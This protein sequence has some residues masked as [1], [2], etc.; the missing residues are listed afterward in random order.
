MTSK[1]EIL[2]RNLDPVGSL[3]KL[4]GGFCHPNKNETSD[5]DD[6]LTDGMDS[7]EPDLS[8]QE[9]DVPI[10][11]K[12]V[13]LQLVSTKAANEH[14]VDGIELKL[15]ETIRNR[16]LIKATHMGRRNRVIRGLGVAF[17]ALLAV[18]ATLFTLHRLGY[19]M[20]DFTFMVDDSSLA[21]R[22]SKP[23]IQIQYNEKKRKIKTAQSAKTEPPSNESIEVE[24]IPRETDFPPVDPVQQKLDVLRSLVHD[25]Q[26]DSDL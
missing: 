18:F 26:T 20:A 17:V 25:L 13:A 24:T 15:P 2:V 19:D 5:D 8:S 9:Q 4:L 6:S 16:E 3:R 23:L 11:S 10:R 22:L 14:P 7:S 21:E 12:N 1:R